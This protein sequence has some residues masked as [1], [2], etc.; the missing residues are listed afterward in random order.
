MT[1]ER[2]QR[3]LNR[4]MELAAGPPSNTFDHVGLVGSYKSPDAELS[5]FP[6]ALWPATSWGLR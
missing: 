6:S 1:T 4:M 2:Y 5:N 3:G